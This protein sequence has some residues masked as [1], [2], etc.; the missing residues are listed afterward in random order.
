MDT[1]SSFPNTPISPARSAAPVIPTDG[2]EISYVSRAIYVGQTGDL[3]VE[4]VDGGAAT[5]ENVAG[6]TVLP[7]R[8][9]EIKATGTT[10]TG[11]VALW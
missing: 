6:G 10:A 4:M 9:K 5:F 11:V 7:I 1:F 2:V 8:V 3:T